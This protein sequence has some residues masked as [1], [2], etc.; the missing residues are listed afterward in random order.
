[1]LFLLLSSTLVSGHFLSDDRPNRG[2]MHGEKGREVQT[3]IQDR[4]PRQVTTL[5]VLDFSEDGDGQPDSNGEY[6]R[7]TLEAGP[8]PEACFPIVYEHVHIHTC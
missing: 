7:A 1:M 6:T 2:S 4:Q 8:L 5:K 3:V